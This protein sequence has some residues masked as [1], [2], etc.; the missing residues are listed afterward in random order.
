MNLTKL[1]GLAPPQCGLCH[2]TETL[3]RCAACQAVYYCSRKCQTRDREVHKAP[4]N[5]TK[6]ARLRYLYESEKLRNLPANPLFEGDIF[7]TGVGRFWSIFETRDYMQARYQYVDALLTRNIAAGGPAEVVQTSLD[8]MEDM[9]RLCR[10]DNLGL[11]DILCFLYVRLGRDQDAY[12]FIKWYATTGQRSDYD[13]GDIENPF[14]DVKGADVLEPPLEKLTGR[15]ASLSHAVTLTLLKVRVLL[16]LRALQKT[17]AAPSGNLVRSVVGSRP[18]LS[19]A[20]PEDRARWIAEIEEQ[21]KRMYRVVKA[22]NSRFWPILID[23]PD[24]GISRRPQA[25]SPGSE[26]EAILIVGYSFA[27]W[28]ETLGAIGI[29]R[30]LA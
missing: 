11:R 14:L 30:T 25:Y 9:L 3:M 21:V 12:D 29:L 16:D 6:K 5:A 26:A 1:N 13:W 2:T 17:S 7:E 19:Q 8:H 20:Q 10:G 4:C 22:R 15:F 24:W 18:D 28:Y 27:A 23:H